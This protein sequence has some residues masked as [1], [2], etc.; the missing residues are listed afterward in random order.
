[1]VNA[2]RNVGRVSIRVMPDTQRFAPQLKQQLELIERRTHF[3]V[4]VDRVN[5]DRDKIQQDINKQTQALKDI[6]SNVEVVIDKARLDK[7]KVRASIQKQFDELG[8]IGVKIAPELTKKKEFLKQVDDLVDKAERNEITIPVDLDDSLF[9]KARLAF[10]SRNRIVK[11]IPQVSA[12]AA[13]KAATAIAALSG[14]RLGF[15]VFDDLTDFLSHLDENLP[16]LTTFTTGI[17]ALVSALVSGVGGLVGIGAGLASMIPALLLVPGLL[18]NGLASLTVLIVALKDGKEQLAELGDGFKNLGKIISTDFWAAAKQPIIQMVNTLMPQLETSMSR[19]AKGIGAFTASMAAAFEVKLADGRLDAIFKNIEEGWYILA[20][21]ADQFAG[22]IVSL[23]E[24]AARYMPRL[25]TW[26]TRIADQF[27]TWLEA[28]ANDGRLDGWIESAITAFYDLGDVLWAT[29]GILEGLWTAAENAGSQGLSGFADQMLRIRDIVQGPEFQE[30]LT[31]IFRG[32]D[33]A[34]QGLARGLG[35]LTR[36]LYDLRGPIE[37]VIGQAGQAFGDILS[38]IA[39]LVNQ[40]LVADGLIAAIDG[41]RRG[42]NDFFAQ[43][44]P[45]VIGELANA[46]GE[47]IGALGTSFGTSLADIINAT[48]PIL[49]DLLTELTGALPEITAAVSSFAEE[50]LPGILENLGEAIPDIVDGITGIA[51]ALGQ[52]APV[53]GGAAELLGNFLEQV[54]KTVESLTALKDDLLFSFNLG[55]KKAEKQDKGDIDWSQGFHDFFAGI[56]EM[57]NQPSPDEETVRERLGLTSADGALQ[58]TGVN[59]LTTQEKIRIFG[60]QSSLSLQE[61][62]NAGSAS[63]NQIA[64]TFN[65]TGGNVDGL[66]SKVSGFSSN[67]AQTLAEKM[68]AGG[69]AVNGLGS[70]FEGQGGKVDGLGVKVDGFS[71]NSESS[72]QGFQTRSSSSWGSHWR[73]MDREPVA[74]TGRIGSG[75]TSGLSGIPGQMVSIGSSMIS[76][77][78]S[79]INSMANRVASA[80]R[81]VVGNAVE[82]AQAALNIN[83]PSRV[84]RD[85]VGKPFVEGLV[86]GL[87]NGQGIASA[88]AK[89]LVL[90]T[91]D[92]A[93]GFSGAM[94]TAG[95]FGGPASGYDPPVSFEFEG[96]AAFKQ[97]VVAIV[98]QQSGKTTRRILAGRVS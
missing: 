93:S 51:T 50:D 79:G 82:A 11:L 65:S 57:W 95:A 33:V 97:E 46:I 8:D 19:T 73:S 68:A 88:A 86:V 2:G 35:D 59:A 41:V 90:A 89:R 14:A 85:K 63:L 37:Y 32:A 12:A 31:G 6:T 81:T 72:L 39:E 54:G 80:A 23:S 36:I 13:A 96:V 84:V 22:A 48:A 60:E 17:I 18:L 69:T 58:T 5:F 1:M 92:T 20:E 45:V 40:P 28:V 21:G 75:I 47:F 56:D 66:G 9:A 16:R 87:E 64:T 74:A 83:S 15:N 26:F 53:V 71:R 55:G 25:A 77:L 70:T 91:V 98:T 78:I 7:P 42:I 29:I 24:I 67:A 62:M 44:D 76:G 30:T 34:T 3:T 38:G 94:S 61:K 10:L 52:L 49:T 4:N 27:D 43:I